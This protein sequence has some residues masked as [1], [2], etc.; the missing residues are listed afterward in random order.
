MTGKPVRCAFVYANPRRP[1]LPEIEAGRAPDTPL[2]GQNHLARLGIDARVHDPPLAGGRRPLLARVAWQARELLL[3]W[4]LG[5][6]DVVCTPLALLLPL[7]ARGR[8]RL[9]TLVLNMGLC[10]RLRRA[11]P[12]QRALIRAALKAAAGTVCFADSQRQRLLQQ[13]G[14]PP[15]RVHVVPFGV[16][17]R[18]YPPTPLPPAGYVLAVGRDLA[19]DYATFARAVASLGVR[20]V[21]VASPRN[22][23]GVRLP[24][25]IEARLDVSYG[26]LRRLYGEAACVVVPTRRESFPFGAD[27]SGHTVVLE[28]MASSRPVVVSE[29]STN[30]EYVRPG[31]TGLQVPPEDPAALR[32]AIERLLADRD[33]AQRL[34]AAGRRAVE[35]RFT[36]R[37]LAER[38]APLIEAAAAG[39][40]G[41]C[42]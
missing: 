23:D 17:E 15:T 12:P 16:D 38:L 24:P 2:L 22:L 25:T 35:E 1:L 11:S 10:T 30:A 4:E 39:E 9:R 18:F 26:E 6:V 40:R 27:C 42:A 21:V 13:T 36:T 14:L 5:H 20:G 33:L 19:R 7:A 41:K 29:R 32:E 28:A 8:G 3:P 31:E 37:H 34:A